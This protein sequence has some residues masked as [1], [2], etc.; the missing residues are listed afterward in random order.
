MEEKK[1]L[2]NALVTPINTARYMNAGHVK[3]LVLSSPSSPSILSPPLASPFAPCTNK[4]AGIRMV[5]GTKN[6]IAKT[7]QP[8]MSSFRLKNLYIRYWMSI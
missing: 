1:T 2:A 7:K 6:E 8:F 5:A 4:T 3:L